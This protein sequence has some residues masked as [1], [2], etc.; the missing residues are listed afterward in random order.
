[1]QSI[2]S[3]LIEGRVEIS[4]TWDAVDALSYL[5]NLSFPETLDAECRSHVISTWSLL[6]A[7]IYVFHEN[8]GDTGER[9]LFSE[10]DG[11]VREAIFPANTVLNAFQLAIAGFAN[12]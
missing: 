3:C 8:L 11:V 5:K 10:E 12:I 2:V 9:I 7:G 1:M 4:S 6:D